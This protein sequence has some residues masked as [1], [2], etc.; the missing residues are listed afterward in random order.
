VLAWKIA[1]RYL[2]AKKSHRA[3]NVISVISMVGVAVASAAIIIVLSVF[4]GFSDLAHSRLTILEPDIKIVPAQR[5]VIDNADS[6]ARA[7]ALL[8][9]VRG[10][11]PTVTERALLIKGDRQRPVMLHAV[12][13]SFASVVSID[14]AVI[15]GTYMNAY[16]DT[17]ACALSVGVAVSTDTRPD[18]DTRLSLYLPRR[19]GRINPANPAAA[20][21]SADFVP[22]AVVRAAQD[23]FDNEGVIIP[24]SSA[25]SLLSYSSEASAIEVALSPGIDPETVMAQIKETAPS[26]KP[27]S[28]LEQLADAFK[29]IEIEKWVTFLLLTFI[30][31]VASFNI[32]STLSLLVIEKRDNMATLRA[33][34]APAATCRNIF[35]IEGWLITTI[36]GIIGIII[37]S[38]LALIQQFTGVITLNGDPA[39]LIV[40]TYPCRLS[41]ADAAVTFGLIIVLGLIIAQSTRL[42]SKNTNQ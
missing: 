20:F 2:L 7:I 1:F 28:R 38:V 39:T 6:L 24:L 27:L 41:P 19:D 3:V 16:A 34:G 8:P 31:V 37:G 23:K 9:G 30:L 33:L 12:P 36:G 26:L 11:M 21:V 17:P 5:K 40:N 15:D 10:A 22:T 13:D 4:N 32:I 29:M 42:F 35:I 14:S 18:P 25:R